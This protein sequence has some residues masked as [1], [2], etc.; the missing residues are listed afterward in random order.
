[1]IR[2]PFSAAVPVALCLLLSSAVPGLTQ[3]A[4]FTSGVANVEKGDYQTAITD[5]TKAAQAQP[6]NEAAWYY[7]GVARFN[8]SQLPEALE[9]LNRAVA[10]SPKRPS[11]RLY[12][13]RVYEAQGAV[14]DAIRVYTEEVGLCQ[15]AAKADALVALGRLYVRTGQADEALRVLAQARDIEPRYVEAYYQSGLAYHSQGKFKDAIDAY[16][17]ATKVLDEWSMLKARLQ[18]LNSIQQREKGATPEDLAQK[19]AKAE[20]F[21]AKAGMWPTL[22]K[23]LGEAYAA[24]GQYIEARVY[25]RHALRRP[26]LGNPSDPDV[27]YRLALSY[28]RDGEQIFTVE[29]RLYASI[30]ALRAATKAANAALE[31]DPNH[32]PS[33]RVLGLV[34]QFEANNFISDATRGVFV[35]SYEEA[36]AEY[37]KSL[38]INPDYVDALVDLA[39]TYVDWAA[40]LAPGSAEQVRSYDKA[41]ELLARAL[42]VAPSS[43]AAKAQMAR[44]DLGTE[45]FSAALKTAQDAL[46][47]NKKD[48]LALNTAG[49]ASY[50]LGN[51]AEAA[52][53]FTTAIEIDPK[54]HQSYTNLGNAFYQ[55]QSWFRAR[56]QY[57]KALDRIPVTKAANTAAQRSYLYYLIAITYHETKMYDQE[58]EAI[59]Q[60][61]VLDA[62]YFEALRQLGRA[63]TEK[64]QYRAA[65]QALE[66]ALDKA[67]D[68]VG[69]AAVQAQLGQMYEREG[70][71]QKATAAYAAA[72]TLNPGNVTAREALAR[73]QG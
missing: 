23:A 50:Y 58:V 62:S 2:A 42:K 20:E 5:L 13:G 25:F 3:N 30:A 40:R 18:R 56:E 64:K 31:L 66:I 43:T 72:L 17:K 63:Y 24:N 41:R 48:Y 7:L 51:N 32:A 27:S 33:R 34:Y 68:D 36:V 44:L 37:E 8:A 16:K 35:H 21:A 54:S 59:N 71:L 14:Q 47:T 55:M 70:S 15:G 12:V 1:M 57:R 45:D 4:D 38:K 53:Y 19:Y 9:A 60:A 26:E 10:L 6:N 52:Q 73:L 69:E 28:M 49:L 29:N 39:A 46:A 22:N 67:V 65:Q 11:T 61:L